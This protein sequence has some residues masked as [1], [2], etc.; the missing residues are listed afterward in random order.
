[1]ING[2]LTDVRGLEP[3][4]TAILGGLRHAAALGSEA[5]RF[6]RRTAVDSIW[7]D[8]PTMLRSDLASRLTAG[9]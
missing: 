1:L 9:F 8:T 2:L 7:C 5:Q 4:P 6:Y 3:V